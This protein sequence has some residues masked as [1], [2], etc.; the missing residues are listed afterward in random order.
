MH[1]GIDTVK[2]GGK[3][4]ETH[5][6]EG[7]NVRKGDLLVSFD[8]QKIHEAGYKTTTPMVV[9]NSDD[10]NELKTLATGAIRAGEKIIEV[11]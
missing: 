1:I 11:K 4:F 10:F 5:V 6:T 7:Q 9:C 3:Y 2:L 8:I